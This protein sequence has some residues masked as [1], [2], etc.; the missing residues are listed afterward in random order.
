MKL[1][2]RQGRA[3]LTKMRR[4][5]QGESPSLIEGAVAEALHA[6][7]WMEGDRDYFGYTDGCQHCGTTY[8]ADQVLTAL[9]FCA[10]LAE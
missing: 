8:R 10:A 1:T 5:N 2:K 3:C 6:I 7:G 4:M 9:A